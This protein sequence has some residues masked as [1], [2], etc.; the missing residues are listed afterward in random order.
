VLPTEV[1]SMLPTQILFLNFLVF[2][3]FCSLL[4][5]TAEPPPGN[6]PHYP[7]WSICMAIY[8]LFSLLY[9][10][11]AN[12]QGHVEVFIFDSAEATTKQLEHQPNQGCMANVMQ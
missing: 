1:L 9:P 10:N 2:A 3:L 7:Q 12:M 6:G 5:M 8:H 11:M 4:Y